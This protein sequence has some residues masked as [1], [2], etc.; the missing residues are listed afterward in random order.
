MSPEA[1][2]TSLQPAALEGQPPAQHRRPHSRLPLLPTP[3]FQQLAR[4]FRQRWLLALTAGA[5]CAIPVMT[6][7]LW[8][9]PKGEVTYTSFALMKIAP[10][11]PYLAFQVGGNARPDY[12]S[13][14]STQVELFRTRLVLQTALRQPAALALPHVQNQPLQV[15]EWLE[16]SIQ[17]DFT[18]ESEV[19]K[20]SLTGT[21]PTEVHVLLNAVRDAYMK[22]VVDYEYQEKKKLIEVLEK[23]YNH[24]NRRLQDDKIAMDKGLAPG[25]IPEN[26]L[27]LQEEY[28]SYQEKLIALEVEAMRRKIRA[29]LLEDKEKLA[30]QVKVPKERVDEQVGADAEIQKLAQAVSDLES[31]IASYEKIL[32]RQQDLDEYRDQLK[33]LK[34]RLEERRQALRPAIERKLLTEAVAK[35][36]ASAQEAKASL[37]TLEE[38]KR[39]LGSMA[40]SRFEKIKKFQTSLVGLKVKSF[41]VTRLKTMATNLGHEIEAGRVELNALKRTCPLQDASP[42]ERRD[43]YRQTRLAGYAGIGTFLLV[44]LGITFWEFHARRIYSE[45]DVTG[46]G[47]LQLLGTLPALPRS[48]RG[49][50]PVLL[51]PD[52][53]FVQAADALTMLVSQEADRRHARIILITSAI[54]GEGKTTLACH[55]AAGLARAGKK[56]LLV[57]ADFL[58]PRVGRYFQKEAS[59]RRAG[60]GELLAGQAELAQVLQATDMPGLWVMPAGKAD[61][62]TLNT[63]PQETFKRACQG[64]REEFDLV[65]VDCSPILP[66]AQTLMLAKQVDAVILAITRCRSRL[67]LVHAACMRLHNLAVP[68]MG[69]VLTRAS[70]VSVTK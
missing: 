60:M 67:P 65:L 18:G 61:Q 58:R 46:P 37:V 41:E 19:L 44:V 42:A 64:L 15:L 3:T 11:E 66:I 59:G 55:L 49:Q 16:N 70:R 35:V 33:S 56:T 12:E 62:E 54:D 68:I 5:A 4:A 6:F 31:R 26:P 27:A 29:S 39:V 51:Q 47:R 43:P 57:D 52:S 10:I 69:A 21:D 14:R 40:E 8:M 20:I 36:E 23:I 50:S 28:D 9:I 30:R 45:T 25:D 2:G 53:R 32:V 34:A 63:L 7:T 13:Y 22:E 48:L 17:A 24:L 1:Q 38:E